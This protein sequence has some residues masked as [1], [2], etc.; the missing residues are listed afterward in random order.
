MQKE[1]L[2]ET[3]I[4]FKRTAEELVGR[5]AEEYNLDLNSSTP[6]TKLLL[7]SNNLWRGNLN[8]EWT[9]WFHGG[10]CDFENINSKQYVHV[11]IVERIYGKIDY[12]NLYKFAKTTESLEHIAEVIKSEKK[13]YQIGLEENV[14]DKSK[15]L[16]HSE[17]NKR[18]QI[19][20]PFLVI[21]KCRI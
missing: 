18:L 1:L 20:R 12:F 6:F 4:L 21:Q 2:L 7:R 19:L 5:L 8:D 10:H 3:V 13:I 11:N 9:Y 14:N 15:N 17:K 16:K